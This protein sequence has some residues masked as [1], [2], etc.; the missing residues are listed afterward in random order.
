MAD[1]TPT[2]ARFWRD[3]GPAARDVITQ[4]TWCV[5]CRVAVEIVDF[6]GEEKPGG[7]LLRG[8]CKI[9]G[10]PVARYVENAEP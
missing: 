4:S 2:A 5:Q 8:T 7:I 9:C 3:L 6:G 10:S 1:F